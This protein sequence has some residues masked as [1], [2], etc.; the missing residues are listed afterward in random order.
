MPTSG[1]I[2]EPLGNLH[3]K[4]IYKVD[5]ILMKVDIVFSFFIP[6]MATELRAGPL[7]LF[8]CVG[9]YRSGSVLRDR[10]Y[11]RDIRQPVNRDGRK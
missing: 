3:G 6:I 7:P 11:D 4:G 9:H 2:Y 8:I 1:E 5:G 10:I